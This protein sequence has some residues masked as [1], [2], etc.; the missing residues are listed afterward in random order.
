MKTKQNYWYRIVEAFFNYANLEAINK[1]TRKELVAILKRTEKE[2]RKL[3]KNAI[4]KTLSFRFGDNTIVYDIQD[5]ERDLNILRTTKENRDLL[6]SQMAT[7]AIS[8]PD[9]LKINFS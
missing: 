5:I 2:E 8:D 4:E 9:F 3:H 6:I 7:A 1:I